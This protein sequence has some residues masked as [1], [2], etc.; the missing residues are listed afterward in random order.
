VTREEFTG[1]AAVFER[2]DRN[3]DGVIDAADRPDSE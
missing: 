1:P 2:K 3:H